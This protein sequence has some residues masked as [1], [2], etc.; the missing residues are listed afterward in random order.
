MHIGYC[1]ESQKVREHWEDHIKMDL[2][3]IGRV[4]MD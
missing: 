2:R 3:E 1:W 4:G